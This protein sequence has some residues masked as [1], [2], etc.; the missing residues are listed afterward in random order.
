[1]PD[2]TFRARP[3][4][5]ERRGLPPCA[6]IWGQAPVPGP[7]AQGGPEAQGGARERSGAGWDLAAWAAAGGAS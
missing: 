1:V 2:P 3:T 4:A 6:P 5:R 7:K